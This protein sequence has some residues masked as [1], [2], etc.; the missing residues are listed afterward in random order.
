MMPNRRLFV[1]ILL[2]LIPGV[3]VFP[4]VANKDKPLHGEWDLKLEKV[5]EIDQ[6]GDEVLGR[7]QGILVSDD[8]VLYLGDD[9]NRKDYI[10]GPGGDLRGSFAKRGEGPGEVQRHGRFFFADDKVIIPDMGRIHY[11]SKTGE[12]LT[13]VRKDCEPHAF[14]D[15]HRLIDAPLS[16]FFLP[17]GKGKIALCDLRSGQD[18]VISE[19]SVFEGGVARDDGQVVVDMI[20]PLFTPLMTIGYS[21]DRLYWGMSDRYT[22]R[23]TDLAGSDITSFSLDRKKT[24]VSRKDKGEYF[25]RDNMPP[26]LLKQIVDSLP[27]DLTYFVRIEVHN[28]LVY[29]FVPDIDLENKTLR[30]RQIDIFSPEGKYLYKTSLDFGKNR[31]HLTSPLGNLVIKSGALYA[32]LQDEGDNVLVA[33]YKIALPTL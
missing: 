8:G 5:W 1:A 11:F 12:Y 25:Q 6:A 16:P 33:K 13:T 28:D 26:D 30:I 24:R 32:V 23:V 4:D 15:E 20:V 31:V 9:G 19:F 22:I 18:T 10:F 29:V 14:V 17:E 3:G 2:F 7:P 27:D 21:G